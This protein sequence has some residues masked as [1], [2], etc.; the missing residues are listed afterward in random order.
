MDVFIQYIWKFDSEYLLILTLS[1]SNYSIPIYIKYIV[2]LN[3]SQYV[4][5]N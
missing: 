3:M 4:L 1:K 5:H 2:Y